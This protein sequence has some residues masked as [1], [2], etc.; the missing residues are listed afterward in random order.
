MQNFGAIYLKHLF[1]SETIS[2]DMHQVTPQFLLFHC[3]SNQIK[4]W[5]S[6]WVRLQGLALY[7]DFA[8][9][10]WDQIHMQVDKSFSLFSHPT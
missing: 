10:G 6:L 3:Q 5:V 8:D 1:Q 2:R 9:F 4:T 7:V